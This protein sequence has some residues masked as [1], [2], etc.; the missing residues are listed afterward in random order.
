MKKI[1]VIL[2]VMVVGIFANSTYRNIDSQSL[3]KKYTED[4]EKK[5]M[6]PS[7]ELYIKHD[8]PYCIKVL[9]FLA[10]NNITV[11]IKDAYDKENATYLLD[12]G[13]KKQVPCL[14]VEEKA[15]YESDRIITFFYEQSRK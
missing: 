12:K 5:S 14:F 6:Q 15:I 11:V 1:I 4:I 3:D 2:S 13:K 10:L 8:C 9:K 7:L